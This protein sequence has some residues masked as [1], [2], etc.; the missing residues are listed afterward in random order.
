MF[1]PET[2]PNPNERDPFFKAAADKIISR[3][4]SMLD[5][6]DGERLYHVEFKSIEDNR[7]VP[8]EKVLEV[9]ITSILDPT[10]IHMT[11][12]PLYPTE[13]ENEN[14]LNS[15]EI[16]EHVSRLLG[17]NPMEIKFIKP[18]GDSVY[19]DDNN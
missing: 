19:D 10:Q 5:V 4:E 7:V 6:I 15:G 18:Y 2:K 13:Q 8:N 3:F 14:Y 11:D 9:W 1:N 16:S 17:S 12:I